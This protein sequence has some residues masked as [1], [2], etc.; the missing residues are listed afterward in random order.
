MPAAYDG[1]AT[2]HC[3]VPSGLAGANSDDAPA[4]KGFAAQLGFRVPNMV[5][6]P[7]TR[8]HYVSNIPMDHTAVLKFVED[9]FIGDK[10]T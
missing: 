6:S 4:V 5:I 2:L 7:F 10:N 8:K 1:T 3:D 9:R